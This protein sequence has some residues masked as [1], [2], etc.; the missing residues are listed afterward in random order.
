[1]SDITTALNDIAIGVG[2]RDHYLPAEP[3][4]LALFIEFDSWGVPIVRRRLVVGWRVTGSDELVI[5]VIPGLPCGLPD[6][7]LI[8]RELHDALGEVVGREALT[9]EIVRRTIENARDNGRLIERDGLP[10]APT[11]RG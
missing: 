10:A 6:F 7:Y 1:M 9:S 2:F 4:T 5:P 8:A 11:Q 3:G